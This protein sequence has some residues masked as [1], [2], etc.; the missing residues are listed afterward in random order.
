MSDGVVYEC[1][2]GCTVA[3]DDGVTVPDE[4]ILLPISGLSMPECEECPNHMDYLA[5]LDPIVNPSETI[6]LCRFSRIHRS[7]R[8]LVKHVCTC[9]PTQPDHI[10]EQ[11]PAQS[12]AILEPAPISETPR[13]D[14]DSVPDVPGMVA[15]GKGFEWVRDE[16]DT[17]RVCRSIEEA[18]DRYTA[19]YGDIRT[20][21]AIAQR[22]NKLVRASQ[23]LAVGTICKISDKAACAANPGGKGKVIALSE[24]KSHAMVEI[25]GDR[26]ATYNYPISLL[27]VSHD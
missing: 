4:S 2:R 14:I 25:I 26:S 17:I 13:P 18:C 12:D 10:P 16:I 21:N 24:D 9:K 23:L 11:T 5:I 27:E 15:I 7:H 6:P 22:Y 19:K 3:M 1:P 20:H 8:N